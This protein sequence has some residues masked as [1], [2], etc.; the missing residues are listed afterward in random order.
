VTRSER[1]AHTANKSKEGEATFCSKCGTL[2]IDAA[3]PT[4]REG[5]V[6]ILMKDPENPSRT[7]YIASG[8]GGDVGDAVP[9]DQLK[10]TN[11]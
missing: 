3:G 1:I 6:M 10:A 7:L 9:C 5:A 4:V 8:P 2:M 11:T